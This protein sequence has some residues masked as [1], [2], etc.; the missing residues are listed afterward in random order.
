MQ[1]VDL[2]KFHPR[3]ADALFR[4]ALRGFIAAALVAI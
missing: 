2:M 4:P 3:A 1:E